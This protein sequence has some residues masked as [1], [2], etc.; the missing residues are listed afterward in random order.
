[1]KATVFLLA[2]AFGVTPSNAFDTPQKLRNVPAR[3]TASFRSA[4]PAPDLPSLL[5]PV[6]AFTT[7]RAADGKRYGGAL[8]F[9]IILAPG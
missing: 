3:K 4:E 2:F 8:V 7:V 6:T 5:S 1:M 9:V